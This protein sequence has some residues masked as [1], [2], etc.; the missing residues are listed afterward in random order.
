MI[1]RPAESRWAG[2][3]GVLRVSWPASVTMLNTT[4]IRFVDGYMVADVGTLS[5]S[6]QF[7][8]GISSFALESFFTGLLA[9]VSTYV[10]QNL[11]AGRPHRCG[12]YAWAGLAL[13]WSAPLLLLPA[14]LFAPT[15]F[16]DWMN[17]AAEL[18]SLE[19]MYFR[20]MALA[21]GL[22]LSC[23]V[24]EQ[25]FYGVHRPLIVLVASVVMLSTNIFANWLLIYGQF[26]LPALGLQGAAIGTVLA[27]ALQMLVLGG[28]FL[29]PWMHRKFHSRRIREASPRNAWALF[30]V[31]WPAGV[32]LSSQ[33]FH[34]VIFAG[35]LV[36]GFFGPAHLAA[37]TAANRWTQVSFMPVVG[38]G[39]ATTAIVGRWIGADRRGLARRRVHTALGLAMAYMAC[40]A[41]AFVL[42]REPMMR[43]FIHAGTESVVDQQTAVRVGKQVLLV[44]A[45]FQVFD[46]LRIVYFGGLRGA[47]D[48]LWPMLATIGTAYGIS[49]GGGYLMTQLAP[50]LESLGPWLAASAFVITVGAL[51]AWRFESG[52]WEKIELVGRSEPAGGQQVTARSPAE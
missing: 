34:W 32:N 18:A 20:Y 36:G 10:S 49:I 25:F 24:L 47:G 14:I 9:V 31:G 12:R 43:L 5:F 45:L 27:W 16:G 17:H 19:A 7:V 41:T 35:V 30:R 26:G 46:G 1:D 22:T 37:T 21:V 28:V 29:S 6:A 50:E 39:L 2:L 3:A 38:I 33:M 44:A 4:I 52:A 13:A 51:M 42:F 8:A 48:T 23:R 40:C 11:G 15:I